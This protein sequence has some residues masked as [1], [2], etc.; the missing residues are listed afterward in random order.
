MRTREPHYDGHGVR[1]EPP[2]R[3]AKICVM[4]LVMAGPPTAAPVH[5]QTKPFEE[6]DA[7][8]RQRIAMDKR[9]AREAA[10]QRRK[11]RDRT[12]AGARDAAAERSAAQPPLPG[13]P[14]APTRRP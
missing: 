5:A 8:R 10:E 1:M 12:A 11:D 13:E 3:I 14:S 6:L 4:A 2:M 7:S 9:M